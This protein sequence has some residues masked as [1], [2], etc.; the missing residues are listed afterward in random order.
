VPAGREYGEERCGVC[1]TV[2]SWVTVNEHDSRHEW[3]VMVMWWPWVSFH[4]CEPLT[5]AGDP[6]ICRGV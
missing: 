5:A 2:V 1:G 3:Q 6:G 4:I